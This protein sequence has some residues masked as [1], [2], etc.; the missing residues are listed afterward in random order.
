ML[1]EWTSEK[2]HFPINLINSRSLPFFVLFKISFL[3][4]EEKQ[5]PLLAF[6]LAINSWISLLF[7][8]MLFSS[9]PFSVSDSNS[10]LQSNHHS[11]QQNER[12]SEKRLNK[13]KLLKCVDYSGFNQKKKIVVEKGKKCISKLRLWLV[14][15]QQWNPI[16]KYLLNQENS[17]LHSN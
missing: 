15:W 2:I 13:I 17:I 12:A 9:S 11:A 16:S 5:V 14:S 6:F 1:Q 4:P 7:C 3:K 8:D 10:H